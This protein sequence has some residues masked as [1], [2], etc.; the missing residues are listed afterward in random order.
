MDVETTASPAAKKQIVW[1]DY[2]SND[3][4]VEKEDDEDDDW[5]SEHPTPKK[6]Y[7]YKV[8]SKFLN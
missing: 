5:D 3:S 1:K 6:K 4:S 2:S 7:N 8:K